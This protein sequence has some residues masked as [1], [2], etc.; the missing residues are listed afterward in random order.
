M[1]HEHLY[2]PAQRCVLAEL[3]EH[4][5]SVNRMMIRNECVIAAQPNLSACDIP[6]WPM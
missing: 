4:A 3:I 5:F 2:S 1:Q 6:V